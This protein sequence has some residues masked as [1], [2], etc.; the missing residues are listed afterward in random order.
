MWMYK[1]IA[2]AYQPCVGRLYYVLNNYIKH[3]YKE[4]YP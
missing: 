2:I 1:Y 4:E 3:K